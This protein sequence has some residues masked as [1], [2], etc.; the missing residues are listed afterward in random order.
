VEPQKQQ[1]NRFIRIFLSSTFSDMKRERD[2]LTL[3][4]FPKLR[5]ICEQREVGFAEVDLRWGITG[6]EAAEGK[7][8]DICLSEIDRCHPFFLGM[9]G[10]RYG[11]VD[12]NAALHLEK[13]NPDLLSFSDRSVTELE[14]RHGALNRKITKTP[15]VYFYFRSHE[16]SEAASSPEY[17]DHTQKLNAMKNEIRESIFPIREDFS[18]PETLGDLIFQD[19]AR[20]IDRLFPVTSIPDVVE[21][22]SL[23]QHWLQ[24]THRF[25]HVPQ[26]EPLAR[27]DRF[28][29]GRKN[30]N[31]LVI[32][33]EP[34]IGKSGML[35]NWL[36]SRRQISNKQQQ[37]LQQGGTTLIQR[38]KGWFRP[39]SDPSTPPMDELL[40]AHFIHGGE[41]KVNWSEPVRD[42]LIV[43]KRE[44]GFFEAIPSR[45]DALAEIL[46]R[47]LHLIASK[48]PVLLVIDGLDELLDSISE[49]IPSWLPTSLPA[50]VRV[51]VTS[52][53]TSLTNTLADNKWQTLAL[54][55]FSKEERKRLIEDYLQSYGKR[56]DQGQTKTLSD[57]H[58]AEN[59]LVLRAI[60]EEL[61]QFGS[62][63][64]LE[65]RIDY[66]LK[67]DDSA[68][69]FQRLLIR[70]E[71]DYD[72]QTDGLVE[73]ILSLIA[74]SHRGLGEGEFLYIMGNK[75]GQPLPR[76]YFAPLSLAL[77]K[78]LV[79]R[80][81]TLSFQ[82]LAFRQA[83]EKRYL[84][85]PEKVDKW[86]RKL[87]AYF[88]AQELGP[89]TLEE[90]PWQ[91][92]ALKAWDD[93]AD[94]LNN[95]EWLVKAW[96][97]NSFELKSHWSQ[98]ES[99]SPHRLVK[100]YQDIKAFPE[101]Y[102]SAA[103][104]LHTLLNDLGYSDSALEF[105]T[106]LINH[107]KNSGDP[108]PLIHTLALQASIHQT[109][110]DF[111]PALDL[112]EEQKNLCFSHGG[113]KEG[114]LRTCMGNLALILG[115]L[116]REQE[117]LALH[118]EEQR[119]CLEVEDSVALAIS[120]GNQ[121]VL[122]MRMGYPDKAM[123]LFKEQQ[124]LSQLSG[125]YR[126]LQASLGNQAKIF[127]EQGKIKAALALHDKEEKICRQVGDRNGL[128]V[129][130]GNQAQ[131][132]MDL[133]DFDQALK[134]L[135][136]KES[137]AHSLKDP[138][139]IIH[140]LLGQA[141]LFA[142]LQQNK[143][144]LSMADN[145]LKLAQEH[146][147]SALSGEIKSLINQIKNKPSISN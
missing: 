103:P 113:D 31:R 14:I 147:L 56:L 13:I 71:S 142:R 125:D 34:G 86:R 92:A 75:S 122:Q 98:I 9:I 129:S 54:K 69:F 118:E 95:P 66:Y 18:T 65:E 93:L 38:V 8:L 24:K 53:T 72:G 87:V 28:L 105:G 82:H 43:M 49:S 104:I 114:G 3:V 123:K 133:G 22:H 37:P 109:K 90:L 116:G 29:A 52:G 84:N 76:R 44:L 126:A 143:L 99:N 80:S 12:A 1:S 100:A 41:S 57:W 74:T 137:L 106:V 131:C 42:I 136:N 5:K 101:K 138:L 4:I 23:Y 7:V 111:F 135:E 17:S 48:R 79:N 128:H 88:S 85:K 97:R 77:E 64:Q 11:W 120:L 132:H 60:L 26:N 27:L 124:K 20:E 67:S 2:H 35:A 140:A 63:E 130:L 96:E 81:G 45:P 112:L 30:E 61:R 94:K 139:G 145:A 73:S 55:G 15:I 121:G 39:G 59:P 19:M 16:A 146:N 58:L 62:F 68:D 40:I 119:L 83:V 141:E 115:Q 36:Y 6:E 127:Q 10:H 50:N 78:F 91:L 32:C 108:L 102:S 47:W 107:L 70:L 117:A 46:N 51:V 25:A 21:R 144:A 33:G 134:L 110:A 89:R